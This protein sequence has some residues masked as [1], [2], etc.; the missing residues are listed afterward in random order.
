MNDQDE[1]RIQ[2]D[3][4]ASWVVN[5]ILSADDEIR[6]I[7]I[8][9]KT[10]L[11]AAQARLTRLHERFDTELA[12]YVSTRLRPGSRTL[13]LP[14]G[15]CGFRR[16]PGGPRVVDHDAVILWAREHLPEVI[17]EEVVVSL[18]ARVVA[19]HC[20]KTGEIP[21]GVEIVPD[22]DTFTVKCKKEEP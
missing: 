18:D 5:Q 2:S 6:R 19:D 20:R 16:V 8:Q 11:A 4:A 14:H 12:E 15:S 21:P 1:F 3:E 22:R 10:L 13:H 9:S 7:T 17:R